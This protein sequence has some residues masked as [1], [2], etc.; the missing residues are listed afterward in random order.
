MVRLL[1]VW[2]CGK[3]AAC[4]YSGKAAACLALWQG[5]HVSGSVA[6][7]LSD[8][9]VRLLSGSVARLLSVWFCGKAAV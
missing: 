4:L 2:L 7:L 9:V 5:C 1:P 3:A 8:S 6:R